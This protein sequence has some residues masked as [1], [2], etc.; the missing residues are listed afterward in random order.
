MYGQPTKYTVKA[1]SR[2]AIDQQ[3]DVIERELQSLA[4]LTRIGGILIT[5]NGSG[6]FTAELSPD[7]PYGVTWNQLGTEDAIPPNGGTAPSIPRQP[8]RPSSPKKKE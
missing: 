5:R 7:V 4:S 3:L 2:R 1:G 8:A 6:S